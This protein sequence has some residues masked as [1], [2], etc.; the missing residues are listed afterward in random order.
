MLCR[1]RLFICS[2]FSVGAQ[3]APG[4]VESSAPAIGSSVRFAGVRENPA[5]ALLAPRESSPE[6]TYFDCW[7]PVRQ[8]RISI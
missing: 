8:L 6:D 7:S 5:L 4:A 3:F 2:A 1:Q